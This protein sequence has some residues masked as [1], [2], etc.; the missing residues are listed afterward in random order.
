[1][2]F[3]VF[4]SRKVQASYDLA[5]FCVCFYAAG[6]VLHIFSNWCHMYKVVK[7]VHGIQADNHCNQSDV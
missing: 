6:I 3:G 2:F 7:A 4:L 1:M 5:S